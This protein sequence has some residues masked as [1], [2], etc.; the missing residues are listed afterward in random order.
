MAELTPEE[1]KELEY[2]QEIKGFLESD[3]YRVYA[4][5]Q[6]MGLLGKEFPDPKQPGWEEAYVK[7]FSLTQAAQTIHS[8]FE[9]LARKGESLRRKSMEEELDDTIAGRPNKYSETD[10]N[11]A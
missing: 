3:A 4:Y 5:P 1:A 7:A 2:C 8:T 9:S 6:I 10:F 11:E